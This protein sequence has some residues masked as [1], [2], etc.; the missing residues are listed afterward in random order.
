MKTEE[1][2][3]K[4]LEFLEDLKSK[5]FQVNNEGIQL[6]YDKKMKIVQKIG[7][8]KWTLGMIEEK[9]PDVKKMI[10]F[11]NHETFEEKVITIF[12]N[13]SNPL[14]SADIGL[15]LNLDYRNI[16]NIFSKLILAKK[17]ILVEG[18]GI[19][20]SPRKFVWNKDEKTN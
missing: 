2:I 20:N 16:N 15:M 3:K 9:N 18:T 6:S 5:F 7:V 14:T 19:K 8:L 13:S 1:E 4:R 12:L 17:I 10:N 11:P